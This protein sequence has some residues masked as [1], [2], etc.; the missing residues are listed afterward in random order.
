MDHNLKSNAGTDLPANWR[1][2]WL[3]IIAG[4]F[5]SNLTS[6][7]VMYALMW[8]IMDEFN[9]ASYM[10]YFALF[11]MLPQAVFSLFVGP[12]IDRYN[13][14]ILLI[15]P[16]LVVA[17][18]AVVLS[19]VGN[20]KGEFPIIWIFGIIF[21]RSLA[22]T[23]QGPTLAAVIPTQV[24][25]D[26]INRANG[27]RGLVMSSTMIIAPAISILLYQV[28]SLRLI[29]LLDV[30]GAIVASL[31]IY[32]AHIPKITSN[33][34]DQKFNFVGDFKEGLRAITSQKGI[35]YFTIF[36][37]LIWMSTSAGSSL[38][39]LLTKQHFHGTLGHASIVE[40]AWSAGAVIGSLIFASVKHWKNRM[41]PIG[42][43]AFAISFL[44]LAGGAL[45]GNMTGFWIFAAVNFLASIM[46]PAMTDLFYAMTH[47]RFKADQLGRVFSVINAFVSFAGVLG[48]LFFGPLADKIGTANLFFWSGIASLVIVLVAASFKSI[49]DLDKGEHKHYDNDEMMSGMHH[50]H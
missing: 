50:H 44:M 30:I 20:T 43:A 36:N 2:N 4:Q 7:I 46:Y 3:S 37:A 25:D 29:I 14:K 32:F 19:I 22:S 48:L 31:T 45:P 13:K 28:I 39:P 26:E 24:P 21:I 41:I 6:M 18:A 11:G 9:S 47:E 23:F 16:D 38:Y 10:T 40:S 34:N 15:I 1:F 33:D 5:A 8:Y 17:L 35:W 12:L 27:M 42:I 49:R